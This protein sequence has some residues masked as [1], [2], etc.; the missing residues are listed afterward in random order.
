[1]AVLRLLTWSFLLV[2]VEHS[3]V[4]GHSVISWQN[5][6]PILRGL[7]S[8]DTGT[9]TVDRNTKE[10]VDELEKKFYETGEE[11]QNT[12]A[13]TLL[14]EKSM[15]SAL[16]DTLGIASV[17]IKR[18]NAPKVCKAQADIIF[19]LD[20]SGSVSTPDFDKQLQF[21]KSLVRKF[22]VGPN[23]VKVGVLQY[24]TYAVQEFNLNTH[25]TEAAILAAV[26]R[27]KQKRGGTNTAF[28]LSTARK[29]SFTAAKGDR[30]NVPNIAI[31]MTDGQSI[32]MA[33]TAREANMLRNI[34]S[35]F[36]IG[37]GSN[38]RTAE[39]KA[40]A[41]D[42]ASKYVFTVADFSAL[43]NVETKL[44]TDACAQAT[45]AP[46]V[47]KAQADIIFIL[48]GSGSV[49]T[50]DFAKQL[51]FI[52]SLVRKFDVGP[53]AVKVGVLQYSTNTVQEFNLNTHNTEAA[54]L[55]AVDRIKQ[56]RG[57]TNTAF[58]LSTAHKS[59]FTA[60]KGDR[61]NVPNIA[62]VMTDGQSN[63][64]A[65]TA[66]EANM[67]R[68]IASVFAIGVGS[69]VRTA[70]LKAMAN[71]PA[72]KYVFTVTDFSA[73]SNIETKLATDA[74]AQATAALP[75]G[76][77][78][79]PEATAAPPVCKAQA[80]IIFILDGSFSVSTPDF[81]KQLQFIKSL[82]RKFEV[83]P[84][85][86]KVGVLQYSTN[87]VQEFNLNTHN[88]EA[89]IS[90]AVDRIKQKRGGTKTAVALSTARTS[91]FTAAKGDRSNVPNIVI[92]MT[93]GKS[94]NMAA[95]AREAN[96][97]RNIA[98]V[99]A[100]G[101][102]RN[103]RTAELK[104]M[105]NDPDSKYVFTVTDF[106]ALSNIETKLATDAC[107]QATA[108]PPVCKAKADIIFIL[109]GSGS[110]SAPDFAKQLQFI[111]SLVRK[112]DVGPNAVKVGVLQY[113]TN[114]VQ[115]FNLNTHNTEAAILAAVDRIKQ[116]RGG[117]N[118]AFA[119]STARKSSFTAAKGD[120][121]NV[122]NI[123]IVMT[124]GQSINMAAT[125][126]EANMLRNIAS[127]F[128]IGVGSNV[129]TAELKAMATDPDSKYVFTVIDFSA[130]SNIETKLATDACARD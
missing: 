22:D 46:P 85:A 129:N 130:L 109:D 75:E 57:I 70:E 126:R 104:A 16:A 73:L 45:A 117:T 66:R 77:A 20:G 41:N 91:S 31:V 23:A 125:A 24:S 7:P 123:A 10:K 128:A 93:D 39:L 110:V 81:A 50:P 88:T 34:A 21:I 42:P 25:N 58:A 36:A 54:I 3:S 61:P 40:M 100:I 121:P 82:V 38:V 94:N 101:V 97:L 83:G 49:S 122:P 9:G 79:T 92:V 76:T 86:V 71:D 72:S 120:R 8:L 48:D 15:E 32:N 18:M 113:S 112:F 115:E 89:A 2:L 1:M 106:S 33:A 116:K 118:T 67:L 11:M 51:Q 102:G 13:K 4:C 17:K 108:A 62:I 78:A 84:N 35:V 6:I 59:S 74:C 60:A 65:A 64:M 63:N 111:K 12:M 56:K 99:F 27:I 53:N 37:V 90:A 30:P 127:V 114:T 26:D 95:T 69:N 107:A 124:D 47:C 80:D 44:A 19:I 52:K 96:M 103:V 119:L 14:Q 68:N 43:S 28:A 29:S 98:S 87:T 55:A 105:A 5:K